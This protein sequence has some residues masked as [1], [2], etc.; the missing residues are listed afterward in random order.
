MKRYFKQSS[1]TSYHL[2][3]QGRFCIAMVFRL[4][5]RRR[6]ATR[7]VDKWRARVA[8]RH[9][10]DAADR[11]LFVC[12]G[13]DTAAICRLAWEAVDLASEATGAL[14][15]CTR[16]LLVCVVRTTF[17]AE[18]LLRC[19][20]RQRFISSLP[21]GV[22]AKSANVDWRGGLGLRQPSGPSWM[23]S[24]PVS[25]EDIAFESVCFQTC[26]KGDCKAMVQAMLTGSFG[27]LHPRLLSQL[28]K[29]DLSSFQPPSSCSVQLFDPRTSRQDDPEL[30][31]GVTR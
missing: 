6:M 23:F 12:P 16:D 3:H 9:V 14:P 20:R 22:S 4:R 28:S 31:A 8:A 29:G 1:H 24:S 2:L 19:C 18:Q 21:S 15:P 7:S 13:E 10:L 11:A 17:A 5:A 26:S 25:L 30:T 27:W